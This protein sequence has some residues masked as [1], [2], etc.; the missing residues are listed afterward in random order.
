VTSGWYQPR[1]FQLLIVLGAQLRL[2]FIL[3]LI[4]LYVSTQGGSV[5]VAHHVFESVSKEAM[6]LSS[7]LV[8]L[9]SK[10]AI[11]QTIN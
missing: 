5:R 11:L 1:Q 10:Y 9:S 7:F 4:E 8:N 3:Y 6:L 2:N